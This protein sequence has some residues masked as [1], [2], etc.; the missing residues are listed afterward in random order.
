VLS[1]GLKDHSVVCFTALLFLTQKKRINK[2]ITI[3]I[4][5]NMQETLK[6]IVSAVM[7]NSMW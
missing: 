3:H 1:L 6:G 7:D 2:Q 5:I 4:S